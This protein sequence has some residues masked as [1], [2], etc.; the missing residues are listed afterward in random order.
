MRPERQVKSGCGHSITHTRDLDVYT[1]ISGN[2]EGG[3]LTCT[4]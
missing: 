1:E 3:M 4:F 2:L